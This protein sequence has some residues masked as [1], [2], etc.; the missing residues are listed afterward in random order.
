MASNCRL[1]S[2]VVGIFW[3]AHVPLTSPLLGLTVNK[4][5]DRSTGIGKRFSRLKTKLG[6]GSQLV[7]HSIRKTVITELLRADVKIET[8]KDI[9]G[10]EQQ[11]VTAKIYYGGATLEM[12]R[13]ALAKLVYPTD[14]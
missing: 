14:A 13:E 10:H 8:V 1:K 2:Q 6:F 3:H 7:F 12:K 9:V 11:G 5:G 4:F